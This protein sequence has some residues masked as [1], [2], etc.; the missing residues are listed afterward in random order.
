MTS[1]HQPRREFLKQSGLG[2]L[3]LTILPSAFGKVAP[4]DRLRVAH[5]GVAGMGNN[6]MKWFSELPEVDIVA[7]CDVDETHLASSLK[8]M[9][10]LRPGKKYRATKIFDIFWTAKISMPLLVPLQTI[11]MRRLLR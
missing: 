10:T 1:K 6:H 7:L 11:G 4:S 8:T 9:E 5:I 2:L 3:G